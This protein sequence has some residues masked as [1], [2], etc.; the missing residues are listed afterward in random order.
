MLQLFLISICLDNA[1]RK[2]SYSKSSTLHHEGQTGHKMVVVGGDKWMHSYS[3]HLLSTE[4]KTMKPPPMEPAPT[5]IAAPV[6]APVVGKKAGWYPV[7]LFLLA[8]V[9]GFPQNW[10]LSILS[11]SGVCGKL[12]NFLYLMYTPPNGILPSGCIMF[13]CV[14][15]SCRH[16]FFHIHLRLINECLVVVKFEEK[17]LREHKWESH[18]TNH[19]VVSF[20]KITEYWDNVSLTNKYWQFHNFVIMFNEIGCILKM[21]IFVFLCKA[22]LPQ[23]YRKRRERGYT[24]FSAFMSIGRFESVVVFKYTKEY[25]H[26]KFKLKI[27]TSNIWTLQYFVIR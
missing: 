25:S 18:G 21:E 6:T 4:V 19:T 24:L 8:S 9:S 22:Y 10:S 26:L 7:V 1:F 27:L 5:P 23:Y 11:S 3:G 2:T 17:T 20:K 14:V 16:Y 15:Q 12:L 13:N